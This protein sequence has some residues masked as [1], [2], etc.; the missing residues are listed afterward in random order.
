MQKLRLLSC[1]FTAFLFSH[2]ASAQTSVYASA[3]LTNY[4]YS[5]QINGNFSYSPGT[6]HTSFYSDGAGISGGAV[7]LFSSASRLKA[8]VDLRGMY[9]PGSRGGAGSFASLRVQFVPQQSPLRP[10]FDIGGGFLTTVYADSAS[11]QTGGRGR[12]TGGAADLNFGLEIRA[13]PRISIKAIELGGFA[14][15]D[16]AHASLGVGVSYRLHPIVL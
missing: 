10:Y 1:V 11:S 4:G 9:S 13:T 7:Y 8:G 16:V 14:G 2:A 3:E 6:G 12:V 15:P 5:S